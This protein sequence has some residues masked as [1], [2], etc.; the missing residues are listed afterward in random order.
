MTITARLS[1]SIFKSV[2]TTLVI[3]SSNAGSGDT[4]SIIILGDST[5]DNGTA[6]AKLN[7]NFSNDVMNINTLGTR[8]T[9]PNK[10]EGRS[11]WTFNDYFTNL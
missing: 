2:Q 11:G 6:V 8:G 9:A 5:T 1:E 7:E 4:K 10:E 3:A